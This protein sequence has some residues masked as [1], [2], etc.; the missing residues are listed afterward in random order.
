[1]NMNE[2][3]F[4]V[5]Q[6][7]ARM[8]YAIPR[9]LHQSGLLDHFYTDICAL[10][11]WPR[12]LKV[13]PRTLRSHGVNR[14]LG[15]VPH[16]VPK[17]K[18]TAMT[19]LG[20]AYYRARSKATNANQTA[21][22]HIDFGKKFCEAI[23]KEGFRSATATYTFNSVGLE[24][25]QAAKHNGLK[26]VM[27]QTIAPRAIE[28]EIYTG[29]V[30]RYPQWGTSVTSGP[31][32]E[33]FIAREESEWKFADH[34]L[35]GSEFV[36]NGIARCGGPIE[37]CRIVPYGVDDRFKIDRGLRQA[38]PLRVLTVGQVCLRKGSPVVWDAAE[39]VGKNAHFRMVGALSLSSAILS[40]KPANMELVGVIPRNEIMEQY[41]WAD[42]FL[43]PS[44]CEGSAT[45]VYEALMAGLPVIC[46]ENT[47]SIIID[48]ESG[49]IV[50]F[51]DPEKIAES[52]LCLA[53]QPERLKKMAIAVKSNAEMANLSAYQLRV[54][55][56]LGFD[57]W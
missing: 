20:W 9:M 24:L 39:I 57:S 42:V 35:C 43:L 3:R 55:K 6:L 14:L 50:P 54:L 7:G 26:T 41:R 36:R 44:L 22:V 21:S 49:F 45:V 37:K 18:I 2:S 30:R 56:N 34:I 31:E 10:K 13:I 40:Q 1:L 17:N 46:T 27:E 48:G 32:I 11:S 29:A 33:A 19:A 47:G 8:H 12:L 38:G 51:L 23:L 5:A 25:M 53:R 15:R 28:L 52:I 16:G 4:L